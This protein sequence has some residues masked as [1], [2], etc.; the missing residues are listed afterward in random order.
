MIRLQW[1]LAQPC[2]GRETLKT[3]IF[4][5]L[6]KD[7]YYR[8]ISS[9]VGPLYLVAG[10]HALNA[11]L[12]KCDLQKP[13]T[14]STLEALPPADNQAVINETEK[15]LNEYFS[16]HRTTFNLPLELHGTD[17]QKAAWQALLTIP[18]GKTASYEAQAIKLGGREKVRA[19]GTANGMNPLSIVIPCH[20]VI[21]KD[22]SLTGFGGGIEAKRW[23][24]D[25]EARLA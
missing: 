17:F 7:S 19:V 6:P 11:I 12:W 9:P 14:R 23:L 4:K 5:K 1:P 22:G 20:R 13:E 21:G 18:Y 2:S 24:I 3:R 15:Q 10:N 16:G 8:V 25:H